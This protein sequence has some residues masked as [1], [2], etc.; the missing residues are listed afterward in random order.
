MP[1]A[2]PQAKR[3]AVLSCPRRATRV[4]SAWIPEDWGDLAR[5]L[6]SCS[7]F[8]VTGREPMRDFF[9]ALTRNWI[10]LLGAALAA[11]SGVLILVLFGIGF[12]GF[13]GG[14]YSGILTYLVLPGFFVTGLAMIPIGAWFERRRIRKMIGRGEPAP[15]FPVIDL[16]RDAV[17]R[18]VLALLSVSVLNVAILALATYKGVEVMD[19]VGFC[20]STCHSVMSPEYTT[21]Q[22]SPHAR[23]MCVSCHIGPGADWFVK[24]K[25]AGSWQLV[26]VT[27]RLYDRPIPVPVH[28]LRPARETCEQCHWPAKFVGDR[29]KVVTRY[30]ADEKNTEKKTVL[31]LKVGG[32]QGRGA[33]GIHWHVDP[34]IQLRY[35]ADETRQ[36]IYE[37]ELKAVDGSLR[38]FVSEGAGDG[39]AGAEKQPEWRVM[40]CID[41]HNRP[42]HVF[43]LAGNEI[44]SALQQGKID[45]SLP[46]VKREGL[47]ALEQDY[48][49]HEE[50]R[51]RIPEQ[52]R[53]FYKKL[54]PALYAS[55]AASVEAAAQT[56]AELY[57]VN[58]FP[59][60]NIRWGNY[61]NHI[62]HQD[63]P[64]CFRC[65]DDAH[66]TADGE[67]ISQDCTICHT[68]LAIEEESPQILNQLNP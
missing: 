28:N 43:R 57:C 53:S 42:S 56:L 16:N 34:G 61:A 66:K 25:L 58:V 27:F 20:G 30:D 50:A 36:T 1:E 59:S 39:D 62:G 65:H 23:V 13:H 45:R 19:S 31:L 37:V 15:A 24:S 68:L 9:I 14:P 22:R 49:S 48:A 2:K 38:R 11:A 46:F 67:T 3:S 4:S 52:I 21:Y 6:L 5:A 64:G 54:D 10:S 18:S 8:S 17:R 26:S 44:D 63:F 41:C 12:I 29:L 51:I 32:V 7:P 33:Q 47:K 40:D 55:K 60:M 35:R